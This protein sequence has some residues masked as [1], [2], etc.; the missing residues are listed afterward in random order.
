MLKYKESIKILICEKNKIFTRVCISVI[1]I[2][3]FTQFTY[4][5]YEDSIRV[6]K[7]LR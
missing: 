5:Y 7:I 4:L 6:K 3:I 1:C 2:F